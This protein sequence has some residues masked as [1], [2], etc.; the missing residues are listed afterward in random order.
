MQIRLLNGFHDKDHHNLLCAEVV[1][2]RE[3]RQ[4][5]SVWTHC[6]VLQ[7]FDFGPRSVPFSQYQKQ[8]AWFWTYRFVVDAEL[9][10]IN[11][12]KQFLQISY[13]ST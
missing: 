4:Q 5:E 7:W 3:V 11:Y 2:V 9:S 12:F 6:S 13:P 10:P 1:R 8:N